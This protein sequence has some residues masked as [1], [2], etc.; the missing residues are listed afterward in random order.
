MLG[1][2]FEVAFANDKGLVRAFVFLSTTCPISNSYVQELN[3]LYKALPSKVELY[4]VVADSSTTRRKAVD[5]FHEFGAAFPILFDGS[6]LLSSL[7]EPTTVPEAFVLAPDGALVYRGA[8]D[9]AYE[10]IGRRRVNV[11]NHYLE[12]SL[13]AAVSGK[14]PAVMQTK[15]V[16]CTI[17]RKPDMPASSAVT[18]ARDIAPILQQRC[19]NCHRPGQVAPFPL[20]NSLKPNHMPR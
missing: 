15:P 4:G 2:L 14:R 8:I 11:E 9:N 16:G 10:S 17:S 1:W 3:R 13:V 12:D 20:T 19:E 7:L 5:H 6:Q 18:Y